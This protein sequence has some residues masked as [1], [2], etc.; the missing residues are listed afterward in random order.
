MDN[1]E[2]PSGKVNEGQFWD[3]TENSKERLRFG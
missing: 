3:M 2:I 1:E